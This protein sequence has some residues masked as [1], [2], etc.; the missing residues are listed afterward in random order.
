MKPTVERSGTV[1]KKTA[2]TNSQSPRQGATEDTHDTTGCHH[3]RHGL[4]NQPS[5]HRD[6]SPVRST[7][8]PPAPNAF[9]DPPAQPN[10]P[11]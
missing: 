8:R 4:S 1:G 7:D 3:Q 6:A 9:R 11:P 10:Q 5:A 2:N